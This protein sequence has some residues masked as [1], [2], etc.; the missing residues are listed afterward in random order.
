[1]SHYVPLRKRTLIAAFVSALFSVLTTERKIAA[2][3][4]IQERK[5][6]RDKIREIALEVHKALALPIPDA[7]KLNELRGSFS[8]LVNPHDNMDQEILRLINANNA[9][10]ADEFRQRVALLLSAQNTRR[11]SGGGWA[12]RRLRVLNSRFL[13]RVINIYTAFGALAKSSCYFFI[14]SSAL[15]LAIFWLLFQCA[16]FFA[17]ASPARCAGW[18]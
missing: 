1:M 4:V 8:L 9:N 15:A 13:I 12:K 2:E 18:A 14:F 17:P 5:N 10:R 3:N 16:T 6:W 7:A 11:A